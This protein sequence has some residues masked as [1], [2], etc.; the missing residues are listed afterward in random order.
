MYRPANNCATILAATRSGTK[1]E[2]SVEGRASCLRAHLL[3]YRFRAMKPRSA[4]EETKG[5]R[6]FP[7]LLDKIRLNAAGKLDPKYR[8][9]LG[10]GLDRRL[11]KF[12]RV[13]F[14]K[15]CDRVRKGGSDEE[16]LEWCYANGHRLYKNDVEIWNE[17]ISKLGWN[18]FATNHLAKRK[19]EAGLS[20][21]DDIQTLVDFFDVDEERNGQTS[22][23][24]TANSR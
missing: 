14:D 23:K 3:G 24:Q 16:I 17:F 2:K 12:L 1:R 22:A 21:R 5:L 20:D 11:I 19:A 10:R 9:D 6:Y 7:R 4:K 15:L 8:E 13:E 18:D